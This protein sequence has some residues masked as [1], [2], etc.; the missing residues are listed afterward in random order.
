MKYTCK[1]YGGGGNEQDGGIWKKKETPKTIIFKYID[2][3]YFEPLYTEI[4]INKFYSKK[5]TRE[6]ENYNAWR[7]QEENGIEYIAW[8]NNGNV[9][10]DWGDGTYTAYPSQAGIPFIFEPIKP[11]FKQ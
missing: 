1:Y 4:K 3:L 5:R 6:D 2:D 11:S 7:R 8:A 9:L 10:R